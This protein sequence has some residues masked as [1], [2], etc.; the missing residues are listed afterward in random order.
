MP[1]ISKNTCFRHTGILPDDP[2]LYKELTILANGTDNI[3][4][5]H[6]C[7]YDF[8]HLELWQFGFR[9]VFT[10][11]ANQHPSDYRM[12]RAA[13]CVFYGIDHPWNT[14]GVLMGN[15]HLPYRAEL[16]GMLCAMEQ[17]NMP[18]WIT[19]DN[20]SVVL[21]ASRI[22]DGDFQACEGCQSSDLWS[23]VVRLVASRGTEFYRI[24][25]IKGRLDLNPEWAQYYTE[26]EET[27][28]QH[29]DILAAR[30]SADAS[31]RG[32][33]ADALALRVELS[34][35]VQRMYLDIWAVAIAELN[36]YTPEFVAI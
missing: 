28:H 26:D 17:A 24:T 5:P 6:V 15:D 7:N 9:R 19:L 27:R 20:E 22:C 1:N 16:K 4:K 18:T 23:R 30:A 35:I 36:V 11:G 25:W 33:A 32:P 34:M 2:E 12:G 8:Y 13:F 14:T 3:F 31:P 29:C 10:D 21:T